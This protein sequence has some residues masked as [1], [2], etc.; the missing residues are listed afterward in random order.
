MNFKLS[1][2]EVFVVPIRFRMR[3]KHALIDRNQNETIF[4]KLTSDVG[5]EGW[6][7]TLTRSYLTGESPETVVTQI[8][9]WWDDLKKLSFSDEHP[10]SILTPF[11]QAADSSAANAA[12]CAID[13]AIYDLWQ[14]SAVCYT[15]Q[16]IQK[17]FAVT[18]PVTLDSHSDYFCRL[19]RLLG[20]KRLK[21][22]TS[23]DTSVLAKLLQRNR[24]FF[25]K[26][27]VDGNASLLAED[28]EQVVELAKY[29]QIDYFEQPFAKY[30]L[31]SAGR[32]VKSGLIK[33][34]ADESLCS[35]EDAKRLIEHKAVHIFNIRLPKNGGITGALEIAKLART[36]SIG[37]QLGSLVGETG[38]LCNAGRLCLSTLDP[39]L[40]EYS[41][42]GLLLKDSP[43]V[44]NVPR[45]ARTMDG[46]FIRTEGFAR[47]DA[48]IIRT[49]SKLCLQCD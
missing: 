40:Y 42:P 30:D 45:L 27:V 17:K 15:D 3:F 22:K 9:S 1:S 18:L 16:K 23:R 13:I 20:F 31:D 24:P 14:R 21:L 12:W 38:L 28:F 33:L 25:D 44:S 34:I 11:W 32:L 41:F 8:R 7:E 5:L 4:V 49:K 6:G 46:V 36:H 2:V 29:G 47:I 19:G 48:A 35:L 43:V 39:E 37:I 26:I 10:A